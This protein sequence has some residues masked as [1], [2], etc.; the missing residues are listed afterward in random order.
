[1]DVGAIPFTAIADYFRIYQIDG[2]FDE[3]LSIIRMMDELYLEFNA[4]ESKK[5]V[6]EKDGGQRTATKN[7]N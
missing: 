5:K 2:D 6:K 1:M 3:F 4:N 7:R